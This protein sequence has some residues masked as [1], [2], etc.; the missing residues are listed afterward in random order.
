MVVGVSRRKLIEVEVVDFLKD[1]KRLAMICVEAA[2]RRCVCKILEDSSIR[3]SRF[4]ASMRAQYAGCKY[5][6]SISYS[7]DLICLSS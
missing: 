2:P 5:S 3:D 4:E 7:I 1:E 6:Y